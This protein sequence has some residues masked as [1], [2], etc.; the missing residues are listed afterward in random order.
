MAV[1]VPPVHRVVLLPCS[2]PSGVQQR[3]KRTGVLRSWPRTWNAFR[4][5][6]FFSI[7]LRPDQTGWWSAAILAAIARSGRSKSWE[8]E[9][10]KPRHGKKIRFDSPA[11]ASNAASEPVAAPEW[12]MNPSSRR[13]MA[14]FVIRS[15]GGLRSMRDPTPAYAVEVSM[16]LRVKCMGQPMLFASIYHEARAI[17]SDLAPSEVP[18]LKRGGEGS[19]AKKRPRWCGALKQLPLI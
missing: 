9:W 19:A 15:Q 17:R 16:S 2:T 10:L 8:V 13:R 6:N 5:W 18:P 12:R 4:V 11:P 3:T 1:P 7:M 14:T